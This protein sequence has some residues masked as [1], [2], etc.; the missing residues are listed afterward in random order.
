MFGVFVVYLSLM[1]SFNGGDI[2]G[3]SRDNN[4]T[5]P[6]NIVGYIDRKVLT[7]NHMLKR[8]YT[9]P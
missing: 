1:I 7:K 4:L 5:D 3:C 8:V 6:C 2:E 9:D